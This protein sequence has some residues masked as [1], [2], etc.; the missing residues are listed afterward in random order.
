M[1]DE[2]T[3]HSLA[4]RTFARLEDLLDAADLD[5]ETAGGVLTIELD[6]GSKL[7]LNRQPPVREIWLAARSGGY[8]FARDGERWFSRRE[9][10]TLADVLRRCVI[11]QGGPAL[12]LGGL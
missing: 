3:F 6:D 2:S 4:D 8:H 9:N 10:A 1:P 12:D 5:F 11:E 7:I